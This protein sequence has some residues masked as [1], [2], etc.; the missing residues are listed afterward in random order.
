VREARI[1]SPLPPELGEATLLARLYRR[2]VFD[3]GATG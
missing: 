2:V 1:A 3:R